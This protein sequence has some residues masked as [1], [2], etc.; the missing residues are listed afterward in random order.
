MVD[1]YYTQMGQQIR[2]DYVRGRR[3]FHEART[4]K[5]SNFGRGVMAAWD[6]GVDANGRNHQPIWPKISQFLDQQA[7]VPEFLLQLVF[8]NWSDITPPL[9]THFLSPVV[10]KQYLDAS[11][12]LRRRLENSLR[13]Q[14]Q[15]FN[16]HRS[17]HLSNGATEQQAACWAIADQE[18]TFT[19]LFRYIIASRLGYTD[20]QTVAEDKARRQVRAMRQLLLTTTWSQLIPK[21][22]L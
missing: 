12:E 14:W 2:E 15:L 10:V 17:L 21:G 6:G 9:P 19:A 8:T 1:S 4:G 3:R 16:T 5:P 18:L 7:I 22:W 13:N 11:E 20:L